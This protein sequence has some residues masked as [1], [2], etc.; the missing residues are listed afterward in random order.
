MPMFD[1]SPRTPWVETMNSHRL[2]P[3][4]ETEG[5]CHEQAHQEGTILCTFT[6]RIIFHLWSFRDPELGHQCPVLLG[7]WFLPSLSAT[8]T[9]RNQN[10]PQ[11]TR[12]KNLGAE[13]S[14]LEGAGPSWRKPVTGESLKSTRALLL[15]LPLFCFLTTMKQTALSHWTVCHDYLVMTPKW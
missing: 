5:V 12:T 14:S 3:T 2:F 7:P 6:N 13:S 8:V 15:P 1:F 11:M 10:V 4:Q 9:V